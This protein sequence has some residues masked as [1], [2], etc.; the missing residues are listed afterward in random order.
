MA[1]LYNVGD[2]VKCQKTGGQTGTKAITPEFLGEVM[3]VKPGGMQ[4]KVRMK[5]ERSAQ[6]HFK[7]FIVD[8]GHMSAA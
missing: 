6:V 4:Y 2:S 8:E 7:G 1:N 3:E 5:P